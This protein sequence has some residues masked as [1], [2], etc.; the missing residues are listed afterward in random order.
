MEN[1]PAFPVVVHDHMDGC[2]KVI[3]G[4]TL[5]DHFAAKTLQGLIIKWHVDKDFDFQDVKG[6][7]K[8]SYDFADAM[9]E[10]REE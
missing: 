2:D 4:M 8:M 6:V 10:V 3:E 5:R 7:S 1:Q 9:M